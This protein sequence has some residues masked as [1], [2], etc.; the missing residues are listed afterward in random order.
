MQEFEENINLYHPHCRQSEESVI[1]SMLAISDDKVPCSEVCEAVSSEEFFFDKHREIFKVIESLS[2]EN[3]PID[4]TTIAP[5][6]P[7]TV[8]VADLVEISEATPTHRRVLAYAKAVR[9][10]AQE[11]EVISCAED[12]V[13]TI[14]GE[15]T[16]E[17]RIAEALNMPTKIDMDHKEHATYGDQLRSYIDTIQFRT[18][19]K[20]ALLGHTTGLIDLDKR[21]NGLRDSD[22]IILAARPAMGKTT[23]MLNIAKQV[24]RN[25]E[26]GIV[27]NFSMEMPA[28]QLLDR[29]VA[30]DGVPLSHLRNGMLNEQDYSALNKSILLQ[31]EHP[32]IID[33]RA[34]LYPAQIRARLAREERKHGK[35]KLVTVDYLQLMQYKTKEGQTVATTKISQALK[36][37]AKE[38]NCPVIALSQL[39][40][41]LENRGAGDKRPRMSDLRDSGAIEQDADIIWF[42]YRDEVYEEG[43]N[44]GVAEL[45][46]AKFRNGETGTD[47]LRADLAHSRFLDL[48]NYQ[49]QEHAVQEQAPYQYN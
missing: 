43:L 27:V 14:K 47:F 13:S 49:P 39:N 42:L 25:K 20:G 31:K 30:S 46:T 23:L 29:M 8:T 34:A 45:I 7:N 35:I 6:L 33:D 26:P 1:G 48:P 37:I 15:G 44:P 11:R 32:L 2:Q 5:R 10:K 18:E 9:E 40:R 38:F 22:L 24:A 28:E 41:S 36:A 12:M 16:A 4:V 21:M 19:N 3:M 17:E